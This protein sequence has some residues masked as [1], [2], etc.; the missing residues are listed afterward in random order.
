MT[1]A[2]MPSSVSIAWRSKKFKYQQPSLMCDMV[3]KLK[4]KTELKQ[5]ND[6]VRTKLKPLLNIQEQ[7]SKT[8]HSHLP[9]PFRLL[10]QLFPRPPKSNNR[11]VRW[12]PASCRWHPR[13]EQPDSLLLTVEME[14]DFYKRNL[15]SGRG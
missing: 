13:Y 1:S 10:N 2:F 14:S 4:K 12:I 9:W 5:K 8:F 6:F 7:E 15:L 3:L 11:L